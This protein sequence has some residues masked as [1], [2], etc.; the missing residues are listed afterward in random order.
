MCLVRLILVMDIWEK[1]LLMSRRV[2]REK[3]GVGLPWSFLAIFLEKSALNWGKNDLI[4]IIYEL[5]FLFKVYFL[6]VSRRKNLIFFPCRSFLSRVVHV[7]QSVLIPRKLASP[8]KFPVTRLSV[9]CFHVDNFLNTKEA[10]SLSLSL[11][12]IFFYLIHMFE[13]TCFRSSHGKL[14][15]EIDTFCYRN[16]CSAKLCERAEF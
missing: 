4:S 2:T 14:F 9:L 13:L 6:G 7:Y 10:L 3:D 15:Y 8:K 5:N 1:Y 11:L 16:R 12:C